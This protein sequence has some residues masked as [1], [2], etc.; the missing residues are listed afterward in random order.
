M[1]TVTYI[2]KSEAA[3]ILTSNRDEAIGRTTLPPSFYDVDGVKMLFPKDGVAGG[4]WIGV[5]EKQRLVCLLNGG[6]VNHV[7]VENY[8]MS[9][10]IVVK[11][12]LKADDLDAHI[13]GLD[14]TG[15]EPFTLIVI[16]WQDQRVAKELVW[17]GKDCHIS[18]LGDTPR[19][20]SSS[21]LYTQ[22]MKKCRK[23][24]FDAFLSKAH[25]T[26]DDLL[27]FHQKAGIGDPNIDVTIDRGQLKT[28]S[29]TQVVKTTSDCV[30]SY[31]DYQRDEV[32][33]SN[34]EFVNL[35]V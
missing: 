15:I 1:C 28:V 23:E 2:P 32:Y 4:S 12:F 27:H 9:R 10:G 22:E 11:E 26:E 25:L 6:F 24:W 31:Y 18:D 29:T 14:L 5:S 13:D 30:M 17:D 7:R 3:F 19:I 21:T 16:D 20:W 34:F 8:R 33:Q 35:D